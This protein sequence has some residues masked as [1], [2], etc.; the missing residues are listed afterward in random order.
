[1]HRLRRNMPSCKTRKSASLAAALV[2]A[3]HVFLCFFHA[4]FWHSEEQK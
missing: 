4:D 1:M 3:L 2:G